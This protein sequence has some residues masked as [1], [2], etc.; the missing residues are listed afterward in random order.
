MT[1]S[2]DG[3]IREYYS[4]TGSLAENA[5]SIRTLY[6]SSGNSGSLRRRYKYLKHAAEIMS[7]AT[8]RE[9]VRRLR[10][11]LAALRRHEAARDPITGKSDLAVAA[12]QASGRKREGDRVWGL[13]SALKRWHPKT[14]EKADGATP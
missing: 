7:S 9:R 11:R 6:F 13:E 12:G 4:F 14:Y 8:E 2:E 10:I 1:R 5:G 3:L